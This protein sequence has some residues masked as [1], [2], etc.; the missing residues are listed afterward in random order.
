MSNSA[1]SVGVQDQLSAVVII[2]DA[3]VQHSLCIKANSAIYF[4]AITSTSVFEDLFLSIK[5]NAS[6]SA[7][8]S[9]DVRYTQL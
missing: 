3:M 6:E 7:D 4:G 9:A 8:N 1:E 2:R 5:T